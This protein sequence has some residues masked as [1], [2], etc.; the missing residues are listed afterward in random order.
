MLRAFHEGMQVQVMIDGETTDA[1]PVAHGVKQGCLLAPALFTFFL[2]AVLTV[3]N[4]DTTKRVHITSCSE[5]KLFDVFC[6]KAKTKVRQLCVRDL[7][8]AD[9]TGFASH[10][11]IDL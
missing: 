8:Y 10:S 4:C 3:S 5:G 11:E 7:L 1:F 6:L 9:D 2:A